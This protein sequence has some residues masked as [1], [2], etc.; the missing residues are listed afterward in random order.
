MSRPGSTYELGR[1][2]G[3]CAATGETLSPG[4]PCVTAL[5]EA[6][7]PAEADAGTPFGLFLRRLDVALPAWEGGFRPAGLFCFWRTTVQEPGKAKR[8]LIDDEALLD[9]F[10]RLEGDERA[11]RVAFRFVLMLML[12]RKRLLKVVEQRTEP[13]GE[14]GVEREV[15]LVLPRG[16]DAAE[17]TPVRVENP[18]LK[19]ADVQ[20]IAE[21]LGE[22]LQGN[23]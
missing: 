14:G 17:G 12:I 1:S 15:W 19:D 9:L 8:M 11:A 3:T 20:E 21:Q 18:R 13:G 2:S 23:W 10:G 4:T 22:V 5:C 7:D 6:P 16:V